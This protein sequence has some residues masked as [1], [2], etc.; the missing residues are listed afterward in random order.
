MEKGN[1]ILAGVVE[2]ATW[3]FVRRLMEN[4]GV[5]FDGVR[6]GDR[7]EAVL[8]TPKFKLELQ[9]KIVP[10]KNEKAN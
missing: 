7:I 3:G 6:K 10:R 5:F 9:G 4:Y 8:S 2:D 1:N